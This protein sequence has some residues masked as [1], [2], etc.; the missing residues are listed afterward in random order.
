MFNFK[1]KFIIIV[2]IFL[3]VIVTFIN[4]DFYYSADI[5]NKTIE[6]SDFF[7][8]D[9]MVVLNDK[10]EIVVREEVYDN[11]TM[12]ELVDKLNRNLYDDLSGKG[13]LYASYSLERGV[14]PYLAV[15]I[16]LL[17]TGC[18]WGCSGLVKRCNNVGGMI[19]NGCNGFAS[20]STLDNGIMAFVDNISKNY[21]AYG[22]TNAD[23]MNPKYAE[24]PTW[25]YNVNK[26]ISIIKN[27]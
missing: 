18:K 4:N 10:N 3:F 7:T 21:V 8:S 1:F 12:E 22:L 26:Y 5:Y 14:D 13:F 17:E 15:A 6:I 27:N 23:L 20:F 16:S 9:D 25:A 19:G 2:T 24:N 11:L